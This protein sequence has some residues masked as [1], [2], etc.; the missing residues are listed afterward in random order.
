MTPFMDGTIHL[1]VP[2]ALGVH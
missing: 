2:V 1:P